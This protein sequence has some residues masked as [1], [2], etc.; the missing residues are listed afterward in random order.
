M[1]SKLPIQ[2][3]YVHCQEYG[4]CILFVIILQLRQPE[5]NYFLHTVGAMTAT[6]RCYCAN[7]VK[8]SIPG[9]KQIAKIQE[10]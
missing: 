6:L 8:I 1:V 9:E 10:K 3:E 5:Y 4:A 7:I 2:L